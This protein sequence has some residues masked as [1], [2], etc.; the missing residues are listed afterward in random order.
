MSPSPEADLE[1]LGVPAEDIP[2]VLAAPGGAEAE[3]RSREL[4]ESDAPV[5]WPNVDGYFYV[6]VF[7]AALPAIRARHAELGVPTHISRETL[8][9][10]GNKMAIYRRTHGVGGLDRQSWL[11][12]HFRGTLFRLGRLQF[13]MLGSVLDVHIPE[14]GPLSPA[15]CDES[16]GAARPFFARYFGRVYTTAV[17]RSWLLDRQLAGYL[18]ETSN[19]I[20]F[21]RRF[22]PTGQAEDGDHDIM[23]FVFRRHPAD[24]AGL[25]QR[26]ALQRAIVAHLRAGGHWR[27]TTG[28]TQLP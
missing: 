16:F 8:A 22:A 3:A 15:A 28:L 7:L 21:Q 1:F 10:L 9:D 2:L 20:R 23:E 13:D 26:T 14:D 12:R 6:H 24:L 18:P 19:I 17:C 11:S 4:L 27:I 25:P 5:A